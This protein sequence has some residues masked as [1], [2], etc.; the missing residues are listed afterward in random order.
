MRVAIDLCASMSGGAL[1]YA[2]N[3]LPL[4]R[5]SAR[6]EYRLV[7]RDSQRARLGEAAQGFEA[8]VAPE[9]THRPGARLVWA[10]LALP[11]LVAR[12]KI[13]LFFS[14]TD[15]PPPLLPCP[16][17]MAVRNPTPY[18]DVATVEERG[19]RARER[20]MRLWTRVAAV[21]ARRVI[22][23]SHAA[24]EA[25]NARLRLPPAK[26]RVVYHG[27]DRVIASGGDGIAP[28]D[29]PR[30]FLLSVSSFYRFKNYLGLVEALARLRE[31]HGIATPLVQCGRE[32]DER[33]ARDVRERVAA[34]GLDVRFLGEVGPSLLAVLYRRARL[35]VF[36]SYL[37]TFGHPLVEAMASGAPIA[38]GDIP[39]SRELCGNA[40]WYFDPHQPS[41][42]ARVLAALWKDDHAR[43][44]LGERGK[45]RGGEFSW[46]RT[47]SE[48]ESVLEEA[49]S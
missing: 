10:Q 30:D 21:R 17:V 9:A 18:T 11:V 47:A 20:L 16:L 25:I 35:F 19:R 41:E 32:I 1:T 43:R 3:L 22:F 46:E 40:A 36:P 5:Q 39:T 12:Q 6:F 15:H 29:L 8:I 49:L 7:L 27:L 33:N 28:A 45:V 37:E 42:I 4:L 48:T 24:A 14:P 44:E 31:E 38:A 23:V 2:R 34:L 26:V 13:D